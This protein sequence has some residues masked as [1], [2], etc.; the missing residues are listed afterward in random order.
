M[1]RSL[2]RTFW[3]TLA[4]VVV[5][6]VL[7][8]SIGQA[9]ESP[10][11][12]AEKS[13]DIERYLNEPLEL[14]D[15][16]VGEHVIKDKIATKFWRNDGGLDKVTFRERNGWYKRVMITF[17]NVSGRPIYGVRAHLYFQP[18]STTTLFSLPLL[19]S[20]S[21]KKG[22]LDPG[23]EISLSVSDQ[24]WV[25]TADIL[26]QHGVDP[27]LASV[28]L[29]IDTVRFSDSLQWSRG[30]LLGRDPDDP[31]RWK[32]MDVKAKP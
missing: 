20:T 16:K 3:L 31:N 21:L 7:L 6:G 12:D 2:L 30:H 14:V 26:K 5:A 9:S 25:L 17:R 10:A 27:D 32:V 29:S 15:L 1:K 22:V 8:N 19:A 23:A 13:L 4:V 11:Q 28:K 24:A 18:P